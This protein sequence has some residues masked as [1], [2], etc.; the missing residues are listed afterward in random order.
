MKTKKWT[1][2]ALSSLLKQYRAGERLCDIARQLDISRTRAKALIDQAE[3]LERRVESPLDGLGARIRNALFS[4]D[5]RTV[6][7]VRAALL[8][9]RIDKAP[10]IGKTSRIEICKWL[11]NLSSNAD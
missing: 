11:T 6:E 8:D 5:I 7:D 2:E 3:R 9:G 1:N 10:N 4:V